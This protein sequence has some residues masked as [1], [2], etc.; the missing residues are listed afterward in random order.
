MDRSRT[1]ERFRETTSRTTM[2][3]PAR[4]S[5]ETQIQVVIGISFFLVDQA[6]GFM[7]QFP[8]FSSSEL[9]SRARLSTRE[10]FVM[11]PSSLRDSKGGARGNP[12]SFARD[13]PPGI[14]MR[15]SIR[16]RCRRMRPN[17]RR[18]DAGNPP[19]W[20]AFGDGPRDAVR[21]GAGRRNPGAQPF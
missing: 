10:L 19:F 21:G 11:I 4:R 17:R 3:A 9:T 1:I 7:V 20:P 8:S 12:A 18:W 15:R 5:V 2:A 14:G 13:G 16:E 6:L